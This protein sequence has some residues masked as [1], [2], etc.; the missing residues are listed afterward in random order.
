[1]DKHVTDIVAYLSWPG[2]LVAFLLGDRQGSRFHLNQSLVIWIA[3]TLVGIVAKW[4]PLFGWLVGLVGGLFCALCWF[5]GIVNALQGVE[6]EVPLL[7]QFR[8]L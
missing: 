4:T 8:L 1:M 6:K 5:I 7:G 2:L 3:S